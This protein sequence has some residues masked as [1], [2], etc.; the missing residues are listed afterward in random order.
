VRIA[1]RVAL[2]LP[3]LAVLG[4][5]GWTA[6]ETS[7]ADAVLREASTE[8]A[9][10]ISRGADLQTGTWASVRERLDESRAMLPTN[11]TTR[12]LRGLLGS[13]RP[14]NAAELSLG[15][16]EMVAAVALRPVS[17]Y[18]WAHLAEAQ[19]RRG[20]PGRNLQY[21]LNRAAE[22]GAAEPGVQRLVVD[23]GLA[24]WDEI[25]P[26]TQASVDRLLAAGFR[27]NPLEMLHISERRGRLD[28]ACRHLAGNARSPDPRLV[29]R[30]ASREATQ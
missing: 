15:V 10:W 22:L 6:V 11:P 4:M 16:D 13:M 27:R 9:S 21:A 23:Y 30:C 26:R 7:R 28:T 1:G 8:M 2:T 24:V 18:S 12:E 17:P 14:D 19:Y 3:L 29:T 25:D 20:E 5:A